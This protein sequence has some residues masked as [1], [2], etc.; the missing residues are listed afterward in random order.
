[1]SG[2]ARKH[3]VFGQHSLRGGEEVKH[4]VTLDVHRRDAHSGSFASE[5][6]CPCDVRFTIDSDRTRTLLEVGFVPILLQ[7]SVEACGE[8]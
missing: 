1:M 7:K 8:Q 4:S 2:I 6:G 3:S 5:L